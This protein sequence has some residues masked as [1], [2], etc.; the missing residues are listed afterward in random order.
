MDTLTDALDRGVGVVIHGPSGV[1][2]TR[3]AADAAEL[4][5]G[6]GRAVRRAAASTAAAAV[7]LGAVAHLV[8]AAPAGASDAELVG[9][10]IGALTEDPEPGL[11]VVDDAHL[12][13]PLT[14]TLLHRLAAGGAATLVLTVPAA[15]P[16]PVSELWKDDLVVRV[17]LTPLTR[18]DVDE[19]ACVVLGGHVDSRTSEQLWRLSHGNPRVLRELV[20]GGREAGRLTARDGLWRWSGPMEPEPTSRLT[21]IVLGQ[22]S[23]IDPAQRGAMELLAVT[24]PLPVRR[25]V[26][27]VGRATVAGLERAGLVAVDRPTDTPGSAQ[28][29]LAIPVHSVVLAEQLPAAEA[30][31]FRRQVVDDGGAGSPTERLR[32]GR[33]LLDGETEDVDAAVLLA[34]AQEA[35]AR[36]D[37]PLAERLAR[38]ALGPCARAPEDGVPADRLPGGPL[39]DPARSRTVL[40][41]SLQWQGR[42]AEAEREAAGGPPAE[43]TAQ[44]TALRALNLQLGLRRPADARQLLDDAAPDRTGLLAGARALL[45]LRSGAVGRA[46]ELGTAVLADR[47]AGPGHAM[48]AAAV[49]TGLAVQGH[50]DD[51]LAAVSVGRRALADRPDQAGPDALAL[52]Q[53][54][55]VALLH[56][57]RIDE[58]VEAADAAHRGAM[59]AEG[60]ARD[61]IAALQCGAA[62]L[63]GGRI[64]VAVRW[65]TEAEH[66]LSRCDP[67]HLRPAG[68]A[69]L[70]TALALLGEQGRAA[71]LLDAFPDTGGLFLPQMLRARVWT[72]AGTH[73]DTEAVALALDGADRAAEAG[74]GAVQAGLLHDAVRLGGAETAAAPL[75]ALADRLRSPLIRTAATHAEALCTADPDLLDAAGAR[76]EEFGALLLA[77]D[78]IAHAASLHHRMGHRRRSS[79]A[80]T[81]AI[82]LAHRC[83]GPRTPALSH[84][85]TPRLTA[86]ERDVARLAASGL[87]NQV[88]ARRLVVSVRTVETHL[89]HAYTK[90]GVEGRG[91]LGSALG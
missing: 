61:A 43:Q 74:Q 54:G 30:G 69:W 91:D 29:R 73:R 31:R 85:A 1:G 64:D 47:G 20:E 79:S 76:F 14:I 67:L 22:L 77:A 10:V 12:L 56:A 81:R 36:S 13:D 51:A 57:G 15:G 41:E 37:H 72:L 59:A 38:A 42:A 50:A 9:H 25:Y 8:P 24:G 17:D 18:T 55:L 34:A 39:G 44:L 4:F 78:A 80:A 71:D 60:P 86:R 6:R 32:A 58:L 2:R 90:L 16:D 40:V 28:A 53:A 35:A 27:L 21:D 48:A 84:L 66:G 19:L 75:R 68:V 62:A 26:E 11:L 33:M 87:S 45:E 23:L 3:V 65:L 7:P 83:G 63:A 46:V 88:I 82:A 52:E 89:A 70:A 49:A 5:R